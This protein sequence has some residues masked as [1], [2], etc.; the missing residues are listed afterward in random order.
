MLYEKKERFKLAFMALEYL[1]KPQYHLHNE[2]E[3]IFNVGDGA[4]AE[5]FINHKKFMLN[6]SEGI[7]IMPGQIHT[8]NTLS[9]GRF[10]MISMPVEYLPKLYTDILNK[11][12]IN[13]VF[14]LKDEDIWKTV[15][16]LWGDT[17][18]INHCNNHSISHTII[19][20][21]TNILLAKLFCKL[22]FQDNGKEYELFKEI[23]LYI[24]KH[25]N[26]QISLTTISRDLKVSAPTISKVFN[27]TA[28]ITIPYHLNWVRAS[29][30]ADLLQASDKNITEI[31]NMVGFG[32]IRNFNRAF[33]EFYGITPSEFKRKKLT[34]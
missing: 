22:D 9:E 30:A 27:A 18:I 6:A 25:Y 5:V 28:G 26:E 17:D 8:T 19:L 7:I 21:Y 31:A 20:G 33:I 34:H 15:H 4:L 2:L 12:P 23:V 1:S 16:G 10:L 3:I 14:S 29:A 32:T 24:A 11:S 13:P